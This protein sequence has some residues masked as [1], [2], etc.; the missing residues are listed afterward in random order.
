MSPPS[1]ITETTTCVVLLL[2][3]QVTVYTRQ[4]NNGSQQENFPGLFKHY[5]RFN[6]I[7][8]R[9]H[10]LEDHATS[11][12]KF[13]YYLMSLMFFCSVSVVGV[14]RPVCGR[15]S[16]WVGTGNSAWVTSQPRCRGWL[17]D[18]VSA[19]HTLQGTCFS[20]DGK[21]RLKTKTCYRETQNTETM[22]SASL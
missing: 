2:R 20:Q 6:C 8:N 1:F 11:A 7:D 5:F 22:L 13:P 12:P 18:T 9:R 3:L 10:S 14:V 19:A 15:N 17:V 21:Y 4:V 16:F